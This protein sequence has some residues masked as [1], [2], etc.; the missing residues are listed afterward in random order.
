MG[1]GVEEGV[2]VA[3]RGDHASAVEYGLDKAPHSGGNK[4]EGL[5]GGV[6]LGGVFKN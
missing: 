5:R 1:E 2:H 6:R 4:G 3:R